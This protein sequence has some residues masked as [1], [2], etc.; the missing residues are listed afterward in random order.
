[1]ANSFFQF[2]K[3]TVHQDR[4]GMKVTTDGCLFGAWVAER[5]NNSAPARL[6]GGLIINNCL[7]IGS[8]TGLLALMLAQKSNF[9][10]DAI[11]IDSNAVEQAKENVI[12]SPFAETIQ[13]IHADAKEFLSEIKYDIIIANPPF[14]ENEL[15]GNDQQKNKAHHDEG[16]LLADLI[17]IIK[18][19][20][21]AEGV[22]FLLLPF[23]RMS[24]IKKLF[25]DNDFSVLQT[26]LV[27][28]TTQHDFFRVM[29][30]GKKKSTNLPEPVV[31][32]IAIKNETGRYTPAF[33]DLLKDYYLHL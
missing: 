4:C 23:K 21:S 11:E 8:G 3:F 19:N 25:I 24:E 26:T 14:Y 22:F 16:L 2:K 6:A 20:L 27:R 10:I 29:I 33:V 15:R 9:P 5:I 30:S 17:K 13:I 7:D 12:A 18:N 1:M 32:E 28:Q 31:D